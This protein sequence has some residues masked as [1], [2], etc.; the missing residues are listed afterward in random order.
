MFQFKTYYK[1]IGINEERIVFST[2]ASGA[3]G[4]SHAEK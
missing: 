4:H 3:L 2:N 1:A